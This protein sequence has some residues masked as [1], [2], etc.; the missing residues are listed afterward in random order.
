[1]ICCLNPD[2][3]QPLNPDNHKFCQSCST[4]LT[5]LLINRFRVLRV[6]SNEGGFGKTYLAE[7]TQLAPKQQGSY[8]LKKATDLFIEE[9][10]RLQDLGE[11]PQ[12]PTL[13]AYFENQGFL[14]LV[15]QF[16]P[17]DNLLAEITQTGNYDETKIRQLLLD[18]LPLLQF[19]H[20]RQVIHRDIKPQNI[21]RRK[22]DNKLVLID[23]G[24][25]KQFTSTIYTQMGT[26]IGSYGYSPFEQIKGGEAYP[27]SDL[28]ALGA[29]CFHLLTGESPFLLW[30]KN[31]FG[32]VD[33]WR[34]YLAI[35][36]SDQ[37]GFVI[38]KLLKFDIQERYQSANDVMRSLQ[39][40]PTVYP[41]QSNNT[42]LGTS[43]SQ[44]SQNQTS[45]TNLKTFNFKVFTTDSRGSVIKISDSSA[46]YFVEDLG[47]GVTLEMVEIPEGSFMMGS[48]K[49]EAERS[50]SESPQH[51]VNVPSFFMGKYPL[52]QEQYQAIMGSNPAHFQGSKRPVEKVSWDDAVTCCQRLILKTGRH[53]TLPSEAQW[54]YACRAGTTTPFYFGES[55]TPDLVNYDGQYPYGLAP[56]GECRQQTTNVGSFPPN[57]FG[58]YDMHGNVWEWCLDD[59]TDNYNNATNNGDAVTGRNEEMRLLRGGSW[60]SLSKY[61]RCADRDCESR[62]DRFIGVGFRVVAVSSRIS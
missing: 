10:K 20:E 3:Q 29:T 33:S 62:D 7:D 55:I 30:A 11:H 58:L 60:L 34:N 17:G 8:A 48:P 54:E 32:W 43:Q 21:M 44:T 36:V 57:N 40:P 53:Y 49:N 41:F 39:L 6:L 27:A 31:G 26:Q 5:A 23:F 12:I 47:N 15:Q 14:Y 46:R 37:L 38:D 4:P 13:F 18:I 22:N 50:D 59:W 35:S 61:C 19:I 25:S 28:F 45:I 1:M 16:I 9:A 56:K 52:T 24:A 2:C 51:R 42:N